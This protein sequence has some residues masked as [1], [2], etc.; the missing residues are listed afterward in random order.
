[1]NESRGLPLPPTGCVALG[2]SLALSVPC[3]TRWIVPNIPSRSHPGLYRPSRPLPIPM[4]GIKGATQEGAEIVFLL[5]GVE[6]GEHRGCYPNDEEKDL[7]GLLLAALRLSL[8][9]DGG[10]TFTRWRCYVGHSQA[11]GN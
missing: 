3:E 2:Q 8:W 5:Q 9:L 1:M 6:G 7:R 10:C 11:T 4:E